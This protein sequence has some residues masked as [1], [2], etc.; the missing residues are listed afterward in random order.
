MTTRAWPSIFFVSKC[1]PGAAV[2]PH[3]GEVVVAAMAGAMG[4][5]SMKPVVT[6]TNERNTVEARAQPKDVEEAPLIEIN[7]RYVE[8]ISPSENLKEQ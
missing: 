8:G 4:E 6:M 3:P 5:D 1:D 7:S 2:E